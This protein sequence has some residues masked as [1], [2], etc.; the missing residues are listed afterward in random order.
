MN[1]NFPGLS[2][3]WLMILALALGVMIVVLIPVSIV[4]GEA[5]KASDWIGFARSVVAGA[6]TLIAGVIA[7]FS[8]QHQI[9]AQEAANERAFN[10]EDEQRATAEANAMLAG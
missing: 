7:W 2:P 4:G 6:M 8:V 3:L 1:N 9:K 5:I 10:R